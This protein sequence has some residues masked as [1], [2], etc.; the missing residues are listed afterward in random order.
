MT[1]KGH[2]PK[3]FAITPTEEYPADAKLMAAATKAE[4]ETHARP[5]IIGKV[6]DGYYK[7]LRDIVLIA[8]NWWNSVPMAVF[9]FLGMYDSRNKRMVPVILHGGDGAEAIVTELRK[10]LPETDVMTA[11]EIND[12][13][14]SADLTPAVDKVMAELGKK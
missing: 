14:L 9:S 1:A 12:N 2:E 11:V 4:A 7:D 8:P 13:D 5:E 10:F 6:S 3:M